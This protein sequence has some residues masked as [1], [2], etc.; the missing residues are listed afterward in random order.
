[1]DVVNLNMEVE[2][3]QDPSKL[4]GELKTFSCFDDTDFGDDVG[5]CLS[6]E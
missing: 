2:R 5:G 1:M 4:E 6:R 3:R